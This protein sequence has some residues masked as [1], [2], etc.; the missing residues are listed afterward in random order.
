MHPNI[1]MTGV[2]ILSY[3]Y[4]GAMALIMLCFML[5]V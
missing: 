5:N 4:V 3:A 2:L 1:V